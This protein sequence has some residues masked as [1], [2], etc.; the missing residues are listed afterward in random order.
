MDEDVLRVVFEELWICEERGHDF[1]CSQSRI[2]C[3]S[4]KTMT[5]LDDELQ[6][7]FGFQNQ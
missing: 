6:A 7:R 4:E 2:V 1:N 5:D 3:K